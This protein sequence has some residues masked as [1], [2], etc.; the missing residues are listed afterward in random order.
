MASYSAEMFWQC[1]T[2]DGEHGKRDALLHVV[3]EV[4]R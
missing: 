3:A 4:L 2:R 1:S